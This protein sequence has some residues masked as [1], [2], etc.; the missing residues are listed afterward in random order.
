MVGGGEI[1]KRQKRGQTFESAKQRSHGR[2]THLEKTAPRRVTGK[3][4]NNVAKRQVRKS[5]IPQRRP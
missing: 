4:K 1:E 3:V 5:R 2:L